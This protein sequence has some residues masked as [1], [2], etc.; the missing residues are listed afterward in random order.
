MSYSKEDI[1]DLDILR[2]LKELGNDGDVLFIK[3]I[4]ELYI[5]Q[6]PVMI[7]NIKEAVLQRDALKMSQTAHAFKGASL[8]LGAKLLSE[9]C[10]KIEFNGKE[11]NFT[12]ITSL[13]G[14]LDEFF[15]ITSDELRKI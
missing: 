13:L 10:K 6:A 14:Q 11:N 3:E 5:E 15:I 9:V 12:D 7:K 8:N 1:L 2:G 4:I